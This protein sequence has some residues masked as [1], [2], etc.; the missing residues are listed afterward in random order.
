MI[1]YTSENQDTR[2]S[3]EYTPS[4]KVKNVKEGLQRGVGQFLAHVVLV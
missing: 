1:K 2:T 4:F 3:K